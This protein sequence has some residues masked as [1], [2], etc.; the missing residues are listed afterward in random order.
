MKLGTYK[1]KIKIHEIL[2]RYC[3]NIMLN[4]VRPRVSKSQREND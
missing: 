4:V 2:F 3:V 1:E